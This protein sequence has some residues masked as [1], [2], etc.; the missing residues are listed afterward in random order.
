MI[1]GARRFPCWLQLLLQIGSC[2]AG[3]CA[4]LLGHLAAVVS[5]SCLTVYVILAGNTWAGVPL[6]RPPPCHVG[7]HV[8]SHVSSHVNVSPAVGHECTLM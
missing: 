7:S 3:W 8:S 4:P 5:D 1:E 6:Q 2:V